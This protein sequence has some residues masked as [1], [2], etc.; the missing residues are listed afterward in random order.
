[1]LARVE[2]IK[3]PNFFA[4]A[5]CRV[6]SSVTECKSGI[7]KGQMIGEFG[8]QYEEVQLS[9]TLAL[10]PQKLERNYYST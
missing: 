4:I 5:L 6:Y 1:M 3:K 2:L 7:A 8:S 9:L 10:G